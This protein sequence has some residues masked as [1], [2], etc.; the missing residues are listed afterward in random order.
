MKLQL[1]ITCLLFCLVTRA[2]LV[3]ET[4]ELSLPGNSGLIA[5]LPAMPQTEQ[6][7]KLQPLK[8]K[9]KGNKILTGSLV[10]VAGA[11]KGFNET[12]QFHWSYFRKKF[13]NANP[14]WFNPA[15]SWRNKYKNGNR[16]EGEKFPLSTSVL[17]AFTDQY[18]LN[19]FINRLAWT[20]TV[21]IK[22]GEG[23]KPLKHYL[24]DMLYYTACHQAGFAL[25]YY[26]F[27]PGGKD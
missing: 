4:D 14:M 23:K 18:H 26:P 15:V 11:S 16:L 19:T 5:E 1:V 12:L 13:P 10:F 21:V 17:V 6:Q 8:W 7:I 20:S 27:S 25:M 24:L 3:K 9:L 22:I 2:Q